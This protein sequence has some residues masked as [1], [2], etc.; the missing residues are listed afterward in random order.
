[1]LIH[2]KKMQGIKKSILFATIIIIVQPA[3]GM[4]MEQYEYRITSTINARD[5]EVTFGGQTITIKKP[6]K[7]IKVAAPFSP[8]VDFIF[9]ENKENTYSVPRIN[10]PGDLLIRIMKFAEGEY[11]IT[12]SSDETGE[13]EI[14][15]IDVPV[16]VQ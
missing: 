8:T 3:L 4:I 7:P 12:L 14:T 2:F 1:M 15:H 9:P 6:A 5:I 10:L 13:E 11:T 16:D